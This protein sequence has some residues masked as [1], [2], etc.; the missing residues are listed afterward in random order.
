[1]SLN[2]V[3]CDHRVIDGAQG[4]RSLQTLKGMLDKSS[5]FKGA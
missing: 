3:S 5:L 2:T 1:V 4:T